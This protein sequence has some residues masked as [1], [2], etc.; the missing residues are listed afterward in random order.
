MV[1]LKSPKKRNSRSPFALWRIPGWKTRKTLFLPVKFPTIWGSYQSAFL[2]VELAYFQSSLIT[3]LFSTSFIPSNLSSQ[4]LSCSFKCRFCF[5]T[6]CTSYEQKLFISSKWSVLFLNFSFYCF[7]ISIYDPLKIPFPPGAKFY[8]QKNK[9]YDCIV[10]L[11]CQCVLFT[12]LCS[13][14]SAL[15]L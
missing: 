13:Y 2:P 15:L 7:Y 10:I 11:F 9:I 5:R 1:E 3:V 4:E 14:S 6:C 12:R 8:W